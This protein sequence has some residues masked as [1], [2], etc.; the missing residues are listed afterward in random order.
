MNTTTS[1]TTTTTNNNKAIY[2]F[3]NIQKQSF[4]TPGANFTYLETNPPP[5]PPPPRQFF[6]GAIVFQKKVCPPKN[7][8]LGYVKIHGFHGNPLC[9]L[10]VGGV[11]RIQ[12]YLTCY[13]S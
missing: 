13:L 1:S 7:I 5:P 6:M 12:S 9:T 8:G 2:D 10:Q 3:M 4:N 11:P